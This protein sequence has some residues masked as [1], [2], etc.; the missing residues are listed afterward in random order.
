MVKYKDAWTI[1]KYIC[2]LMEDYGRSS[3]WHEDLT[4]FSKNRYMS[5]SEYLGELNLL[6]DRMLEDYDM[7]VY[8][9]ELQRLKKDI[10]K[11][12]SGL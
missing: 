2:Q 6:I 12:F 7:R 11:L 10:I 8:H 4:W 3:K 5:P 9:R 1:Q